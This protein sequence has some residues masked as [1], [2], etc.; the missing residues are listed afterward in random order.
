MHVITPFQQEN[1]FLSDR[2]P[3]PAFTVDEQ[4]YRWLPTIVVATADKFARFPYEPLCASL[5]GNIDHYHCIHGFYRR[6]QHTSDNKKE[7][8]SPNGRGGN[9]NFKEIPPI[10]TPDLIIQD[11]LHLIDGPL[12]SLAGLMKLQ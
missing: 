9:L 7:H 8:P 4:I 6:F 2:I 1:P 12:G 3:I 11:E 5:T 10:R